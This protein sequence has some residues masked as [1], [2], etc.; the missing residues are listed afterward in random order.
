MLVVVNTLKG[1]LS[2]DTIRAA[3]LDRKSLL[4]EAGGGAHCASF[5][6][7]LKVFGNWTVCFFCLRT[8]CGRRWYLKIIFSLYR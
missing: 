7:A 8:H 5:N 4:E 3:G 2:Y 1:H 6:A